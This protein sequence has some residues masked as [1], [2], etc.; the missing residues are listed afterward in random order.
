MRHFDSRI[1]SIL[2]ELIVSKEA[3][4]E[5]F[6]NSLFVLDPDFR[7]YQYALRTTQRSIYNN[8]ALLYRHWERFNVIFVEADDA[9]KILEVG[10][11]YGDIALELS[12]VGKMM[13]MLDINKTCL[14]IAKRRLKKFAL[15][16]DV[17]LGDAH[18]LPFKNDT[19]D[20][21]YSNQVVEHVSLPYKILGEKLR[22]SKMVALVLSANNVQSRVLPIVSFVYYRLLK[23]TTTEIVPD[24]QGYDEILYLNCQSLPINHMISVMLMRVGISI[25]FFKKILAGNTVKIYYRKKKA[26]KKQVVFLE[27]K[28]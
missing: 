16:A 4:D 5:I 17:V 11:G 15:D 9:K 8:L 21:S 7:A 27:S 23:C 24:L 12:N 28:A 19:F 25:P 1:T 3:E 2:S 10:C 13:V 26:N 14:Q 20:A 22:V 18:Q 6:L